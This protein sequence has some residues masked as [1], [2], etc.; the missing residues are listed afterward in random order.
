MVVC[1]SA[2][3]RKVLLFNFIPSKYTDFNC[4]L[5]SLVPGACQKE[6][7]TY[8]VWSPPHAFYIMYLDGF[9]VYMYVIICFW[10]LC[11]I[12]HAL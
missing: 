6:L 10:V 3:F 1:I 7:S 8:H 9:S 4:C 5:L 2:I 12:L 11:N